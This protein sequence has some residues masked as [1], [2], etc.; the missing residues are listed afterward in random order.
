MGL[1]QSQ[2]DFFHDAHQVDG[3]QI[4]IYAYLARVER[5]LWRDAPWWQQQQQHVQGDDAQVDPSDTSTRAIAAPTTDS[6]ASA[7]VVTDPAKRLVR[8]LSTLLSLAPTV[9]H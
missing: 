4:E 3:D 2:A 7:L 9:L 1:A 6:A 8:T 5:S